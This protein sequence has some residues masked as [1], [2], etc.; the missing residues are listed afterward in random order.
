MSKKKKESTT[1]DTKQ[2]TL[3]VE[4][5]HCSACEV[6]IEKKLLKS[7]GVEAV[8]V[9]MSDG[10]VSLVLRGKDKP[11]L[12][13]LNNDF[14]EFGYKFSDK[15]SETTNPAFISFDKN[16]GVRVNK[17]KAKNFLSGL[18]ITIL[19]IIGFL[20]FEKTGIARG[21]SIDSN[22][23][24]GGFFVFGIVAGLS[25]C[26]ALVGGVL[27]SMVK[28]WNEL[29]IDSESQAEKAKPHIM[30]HAGRLISYAFLG[31][32][33][34][35]I[36]EIFSLSLETM[37]ILVIIVSIIMFILGLQM[38]NV[39]WAQKIRFSLPKS[40]T[41]FASDEKN[42]K[43]QYMPFFTGWATFFLPCGF[44]LIAQ[45]IALSSGNILRGSLIMFMFALGTLP[46]L[47]AISYSGLLFNKKP[48]LT[49][50]FN[51][52][53]GLLVIMFAI[54]N[55]NSQLNVLGLPSL[56]D[57]RSYNNNVAEKQIVE[58]ADNDEQVLKII[59]KEFDYIPVNGT[60]LKAGIPVVLEVDN[61]GIQ[62]CGTYM[63]A[64]GLFE[65]EFYALKL[66]KNEIRFTPEKKGSYKLTCSMGM[67]P[68]VVLTVV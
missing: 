37:S 28:Q 34:G 62:G 54:Y 15:K 35:A 22:S 55:L 6:L 31:A 2:C 57:I 48:H 27:L 56:S 1:E 42:F 23:T 58:V 7:E 8:D 50:K 43:G 18:G 38:L 39:K 12:S 16:G 63:A 3:Y 46:T 26:A 17:K 41:R 21:V 68:P 13:S 36:G 33:L 45:G 44:T 52:V 24:I 25:S 49:T 4:G 20:L 53:A 61:Q 9:S 64:R 29:Y 14:K 40:F 66:G 47:I 30:F 11:K 51:L 67:V 19:I 65:E 59:A 5:M 60:T 32:A 10:S